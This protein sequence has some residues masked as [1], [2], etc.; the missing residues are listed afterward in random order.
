[1][2]GDRIAVDPK[3]GDLP[4]AGRGDERYMPKRLA[5]R[6]VR[7]VHLDHRRIDG[8]HCVP[9]SDGRVRIPARVEDD[10]VGTIRPGS[11]QPV[12]EL[13]F[14]VALEE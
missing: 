10:R 13:P 4:D 1:M 5:R 12:D 14:V 6:D 2:D 3:S 11:M 8:G 9:Q 7:D